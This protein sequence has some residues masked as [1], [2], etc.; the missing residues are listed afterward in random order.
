[1]EAADESSPAR[2]PLWRRALLAIALFVLAF[3]LTRATRL[4]DWDGKWNSDEPEWVAIS[5]LH[6]RQ[7]VHGEPPAGAELEDKLKPEHRS[8]DP[9]AQGVQSTVFGYMNPGVPKLLLGAVLNANGYDKASPLVFQ[10]FHRDDVQA[11]IAARA[12]LLPARE[13]GVDV[14]TTLVA[15]S[16]VLLFFA[17]RSLTPG[18]AGWLGGALA[19]GLWLAA[20]TVRYTSTYIRTDHFMLPWCAAALVYALARVEAISG[21]RG[22]RASLRAAAVLGLFAGLA[23]SSKLNGALIGVAV[24]L[25]FA[26]LQMQRR[27]AGVLWKSDGPA[28]PVALAGAITCSIFY[29]VNP[30][31]WREPIAGVRDMLERWD[32]YVALERVRWKAP[33]DNTPLNNASLFFRDLLKYGDAPSQSIGPGLG[34]A[35]ALIGV[36]LL[37]H[38]ALRS[39]DR[40][41]G[42]RAAIALTFAF[43][44]TLGTAIWLPWSVGR[45]YLPATPS[46]TILQAVAIATL[47]EC[48][49]RAVSRQTGDAQR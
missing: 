19:F 6:W 10:V 48:V 14:I 22:L 39:R 2:A 21:A 3:A 47:V 11:G 38:R 12:E 20:P 8:D 45:F 16:A 23:V 44:L 37:A 36:A 5:I 49:R 46:L 17:A 7:L 35:L 24:A 31:L 25:W 18:L 33:G 13:I 1:M 4:G 29:A 28:A 41:A 40:E 30:R 32:K 43:V 15:A 27:G 42:G 26:W 34:F 9:W